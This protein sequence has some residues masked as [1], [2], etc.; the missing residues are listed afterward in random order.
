MPAFVVRRSVRRNCALFAFVLTLAAWDCVAQAAGSDNG[1]SLVQLMQRFSHRQHA[2]ASYAERYFISPLD[3]PIE[4][5]GEL[6][7][8]APDHLEKRVITPKSVS[9]ILDHGTLSVH[10]GNRSSVLP[11]AGNATIAPLIDSV[12]AIL[13]GDLAALN[14]TY[15]LDLEPAAADRWRLVLV[16]RDPKLAAV[17]AKMQVSGV[18]GVINTIGFQRPGGDHSEMTISALSDQ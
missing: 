10:R 12:R 4:T 2:H 15:E 1:T 9:L 16:P 18:G 13:A 5:S 7:Y 8:D 3:R 11:L 17:V 14:R 6:F